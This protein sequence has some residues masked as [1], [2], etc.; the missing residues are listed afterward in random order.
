[1]IKFPKIEQFK[2]VIRNVA[3]QT[4]FQ[5]LDEDGQ[6][7]YDGTIIKPTL[8]FRG[9]V[10]LH[11]TNASVILNPD[12]SIEVQSRNRMLTLTSDNAGFAMFVLGTTGKELW[13]TLIRKL[14]KDAKVEVA[15]DEKVILYGEFCGGNIQKGVALSQLTKRFIAFGLRV[16]EGESTRWIDT[17]T[18]GNF[19]LDDDLVFSIFD[20]RFPCYEIDI[21]FE[22]PAVSRNEMIKVVEAVEKECPVGK[23]FGVSGIGE[24]IVFQ[25][26]DP[27]YFNFGG[28]FKVK[29]NLHS[30]SKVRTL[31]P[32]D[33]EKLASVNEFTESTVTE[34]RCLQGIE[35]L[36][37]QQLEISQKSTGSFIRWMIGDIV[38]EE[39]D[40]M[41]ASDISVKE[42]GKPISTVARRWLFAYID[43]DLTL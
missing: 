17:R 43:N 31:A 38:S 13:T 2:N 10:K 12:D 24:G 7:I 35:F 11:G 20:E 42:I 23:A 39:M 9:T 6:P 15:Q 22:N 32:V 1:M 27:K 14:L 19:N 8:R 28:T 34:N 4:A 37:E 21:D 26:T 18:S 30:V 36:K 25:C 29:G 3:N 41:I 40:L 5:G 33:V 16:G